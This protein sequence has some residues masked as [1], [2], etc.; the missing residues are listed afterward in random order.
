MEY[1]TIEIKIDKTGKVFLEVSGAKG[2]QCLALTKDL[3]EVLGEVEKRDF[4][5]E[6]NDED[7]GEDNYLTSNL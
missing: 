5:P 3:E 4:K 6:Y 7:Y 1:Q 2:K